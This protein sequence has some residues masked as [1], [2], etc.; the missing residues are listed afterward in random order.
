MNQEEET[1]A[2][3]PKN[4]PV[5]QVRF[6]N[7]KAAVWRKELEHGTMFSVT[8]CRAYVTKT[9]DGETEWQYS[10]SF[11]RDDLLVL[12]KALDECHSWIYAQRS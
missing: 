8:V 10:D 2:T 9:D 6:G 3:G 1:T 4:R 5:H 11:G 7:V 12:A